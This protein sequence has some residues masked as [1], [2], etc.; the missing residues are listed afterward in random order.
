LKTGSL[1]GPWNLTKINVKSLVSAASLAFFAVHDIQLL[2]VLFAVGAAL[3]AVDS[4]FLYLVVISV[5]FV[6]SGD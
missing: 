5:L 3:F 2:N 1:I 6:L 4:F